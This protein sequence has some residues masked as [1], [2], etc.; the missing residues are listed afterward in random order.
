MSTQ[1]PRQELLTY[2]K[3]IQIY[4][5]RKF[6]LKTIEYLQEGKLQQAINEY[7]KCN[8]YPEKSLDDYVYGMI[9]M[10]CYHSEDENLR[11]QGINRINKLKERFDPKTIIL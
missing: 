1:F 10:T 4:R 7:I 9:I 3:D 6:A 8:W 11:K 5:S 2:R